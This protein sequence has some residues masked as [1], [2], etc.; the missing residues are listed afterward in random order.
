MAHEHQVLTASLA[1][2][3]A[4]CVLWN[5][6][7]EGREAEQPREAGLS[8]NNAESPSAEHRNTTPASHPEAEEA[9]A[10]CGGLGAGRCLPLHIQALLS[11]WSTVGKDSW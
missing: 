4:N 8:K 10:H 6:N 1:L 9:S 2:S 11:L 3:K 7:D 5:Y